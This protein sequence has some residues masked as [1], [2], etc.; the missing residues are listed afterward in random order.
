MAFTVGTSLGH[1]A[2]TAL[3]GDIGDIG[4]GGTGQACGRPKRHVDSRGVSGV[5]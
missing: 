3:I 4:E 2:V 5:G 1:Y